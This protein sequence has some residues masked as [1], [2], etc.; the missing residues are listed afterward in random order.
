MFDTMFVI[1]SGIIAGIIM[2]IIAMVLN[3]IKFTTLD[4]TKYFGGLLTGQATGTVNFVAG[5]TLHIFASA[6]IA[7]IYVYLINTF[8]L[9]INLRTALHFGIIHT[10][11][12][13]TMLAA[14]DTINPCVAQGTIKRMGYFASNYKITAVI[15]FVVGHMIFA[16]LVFMQLAQ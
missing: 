9:I 7:L 14:I 1:Q 12:S 5:F 3:K 4:L 2:G 13:G 10:L 15:T 11:L 6:L 8:H 16:V